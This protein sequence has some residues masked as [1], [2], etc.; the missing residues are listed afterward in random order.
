VAPPADCK[1]NDEGAR[2]RV[3]VLL[4][5]GT[6]ELSRGTTRGAA[7]G[8]VVAQREAEAAES[9]GQGLPTAGPPPIPFVAA[10]TPT[11]DLARPLLGALRGQPG[12]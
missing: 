4:V 9:A 6:A 3:R 7:G 2:A 5:V 1:Q 11:A 12:G 10:P 8:C